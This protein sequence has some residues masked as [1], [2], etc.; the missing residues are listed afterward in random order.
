MRRV[1]LAVHN[2]CALHD[3]GWAHPEHQGR[4]PAVV[5]A[6]ERD[7]PTLLPYMVQRTPAPATLAQIARVHTA[8]LVQRNE[9]LGLEAERTGTPQ[10]VDHETVM[11]PASWR[12]VL[13]AAGTAIDAANALVDGDA[14]AAFALA[15]PP[16]HHATADTSMGFCIFN[17]VAVAARAV[18]AER[19]VGRV[20]I[21]DWDVHHGNGTQDIFYQDPSVYYLSLHQSP[22][23][24]HT[25]AAEE[26]GAGRGRNTTRNVPIPAR[27]PRAEYLH[28]FDSALASALDE[29]TPELVLVSAGFDCLHNDPLGQLLLEPEDMHTL[30]RTVIDAAAGVNAGVGFLLEGGYDPQRTGLGVVNVLRAAA[31]ESPLA[32]ST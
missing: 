26:R 31:G 21:I 19:A 10:A 23:Y 22:W 30:A 17:N 9:Q 13:A 20:L 5:Q 24:P 7:T 12:A 18:Q 27:T 8:A 3:P 4:L 15:R 2:D 32:A 16:G 14:D 29:F 11:S 6:I 1:A 28:T 25:G